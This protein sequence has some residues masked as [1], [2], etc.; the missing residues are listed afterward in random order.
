MTTL[1]ERLEE[2]RKRSSYLQFLSVEIRKLSRTLWT[3]GPPRSPSECS[4]L[5][6]RLRFFK[7]EC[8]EM[9]DTDDEI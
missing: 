2:T 3:P 4:M 6:G 9:E 1:K 5:N 8:S 7:S